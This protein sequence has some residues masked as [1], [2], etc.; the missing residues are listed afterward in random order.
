[1]VTVLVLCEGFVQA[2]FLF[3]NLQQ[4]LDSATPNDE[5]CEIMATA[6]Q[7]FAVASQCWYFWV[8]VYLFFAIRSYPVPPLWVQHA[9]SWGYSA[10]AALIPVLFKS[11]GQSKGYYGWECWVRDDWGWLYYGL[12]WLA[13]VFLIYLGRQLH[14]SKMFATSL[15]ERH[16]WRLVL[17]L[18]AYIL[19]AL[20]SSVLVFVDSGD[21]VLDWVGFVVYGS[22]GTVASLT[23]FAGPWILRMVGGP[24]RQEESFFFTSPTPPPT[25]CCWCLKKSKPIEAIDCGTYAGSQGREGGNYGAVGAASDSP[26]ETQSIK[27]QFSEDPSFDEESMGLADHSGVMPFLQGPTGH[28]DSIMGGDARVSFES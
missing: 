27:Q 2:K 20:L 13:F 18:V 23:W 7:F 6:D 24:T 17:F 11:Y 9:S 4:S 10:I 19:M 3:S 28:D 12:F 25:T 26:P 15:N 22:K 5:V 1:V 14:R 21:R 16:V 8:L